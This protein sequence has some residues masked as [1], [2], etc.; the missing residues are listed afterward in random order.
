[1]NLAMLH[2]LH[3]RRSS[4]GFFY[5]NLNE[6]TFLYGNN[7]Y[8]NRIISDFKKYISVRSFLCLKNQWFFVLWM[9]LQAKNAMTRK[10]G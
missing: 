7:K 5:A 1:M 6:K 3:F 9:A 2:M 4:S 8:G 10:I